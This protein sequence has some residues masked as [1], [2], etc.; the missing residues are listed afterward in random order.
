MKVSRSTVAKA[1]SKV[2]VIAIAIAKGYRTPEILFY[3]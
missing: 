1:K 3:S 2:K